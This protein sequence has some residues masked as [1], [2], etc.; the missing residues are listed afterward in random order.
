MIPKYNNDGETI[1][2]IDSFHGYR[3]L[4]MYYAYD[5]EFGES[6]NNFQDDIVL[7]PSGYN[8]EPEKVKNGTY[9]LT[10]E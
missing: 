10:S 5:H 6:K 9:G 4:R 3:W 8:I 7:L 1:I 2:R